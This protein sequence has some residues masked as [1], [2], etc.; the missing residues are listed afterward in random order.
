MIARSHIVTL[1]ETRLAILRKTS[2]S[3]A[4][5]NAIR[6]TESA[7]SGHLACERRFQQL[8]IESDR[9]EAVK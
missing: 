1:L 9:R 8:T 7:I 5:E 2:P 6:R 4:T 3:P